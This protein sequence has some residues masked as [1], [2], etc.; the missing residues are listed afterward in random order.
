MKRV[1]LLLTALFLFF[2]SASATDIRSV[3]TE[4][5]LY[6]NGNALVYQRWDVNVTR[7]TEWYIPIENLGKRSIR[8]L[9]VFENDRRFEDDGRSW[10]SNRTLEQKKYR[11]GIVEKADG[12]ELCWG[13]GDYGDHVYEIL[14]IIDNLVQ[15]MDDDDN[16]GFNW[17]FVNEDLPSAPDSVSLVFMNKVDS[18]QVWVA[19]E[20]GNMG[21]WVFGCEADYRIEDGDVIIESTEP[22][23]AEDR[24][25]VMMRFDRGLFNPS[26]TDDRS[27]AQM[28]DEAFKD[29]DYYIDDDDYGQDTE[30]KIRRFVLWFVGIILGI[31]LLIFLLPALIEI[32]FRRV[33]GRRYEEKVFGRKT[34]DG[35]YR[36]VPL[37]GRLDAAYSLLSTGDNLSW[38]FKLFPQLIGAYFL[39]WVQKG[40]VSAEPDPIKEG[41]MNLQFASAYPPDGQFTDPMERSLYTCARSAAGKN[42]LLETDEFNKWSENNYERVLGWQDYAKTTGAEVWN[43]LSEEERCHL[44]EFRNFLDNFTLSDERSVPEVGIWQEYLV[45]A[46]LFGIAEKVSKS[47]EKLYPN[48]YADYAAQSHMTDAA[49]SYELMRSVGK[50]SSRFVDAA[51]NKKAEK[52]AEGRGGSSSGSRS[53]YYGGGGHSSRSGGGGYSGGGRGGGS[54]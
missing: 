4:V 6:R 51:N 42:L 43:P 21:V 14:Y 41:R 1:L 26:A 18:S 10:D 12:V 16:D 27:F 32:L 47:F 53:R 36:D 33:T 50:S 11:C 37:D 3:N 29:S 34:I 19:G 17:C 15:R 23:L 30:R 24:L 46:Q 7:G 35:W 45:F 28:M 49:A 9:R 8:D 39:R 52:E 5:W 44:A 48:L 31:P 20:D 25:S 22:L 2:A 40:L 13:Q 38:D 54:R